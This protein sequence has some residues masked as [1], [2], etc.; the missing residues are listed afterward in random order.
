M[1][2]DEDDIILCVLFQLKS[3]PPAW[4]G[5]IQTKYG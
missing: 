4:A 3:T 2:G 5:T 1:G